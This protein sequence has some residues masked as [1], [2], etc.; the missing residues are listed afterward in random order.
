MGGV[1]IRTQR[2]SLVLVLCVWYYK[3]SLRAR[4]IDECVFNIGEYQSEERAVQVLDEIQKH[5]QSGN[6]GVY[7]M[8]KE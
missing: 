7:I 4:S 1:W 2:M 3:G 8:P 5:I 6:N